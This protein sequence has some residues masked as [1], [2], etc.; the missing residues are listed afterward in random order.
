MGRMKVMKEKKEKKSEV[1]AHG[2]RTATRPAPRCEFF[3]K[4]SV[5]GANARDSGSY[6]QATSRAHLPPRGNR[7]AELRRLRD[8]QK[9]K[10]GHRNRM[11]QRCLMILMP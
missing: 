5:G 2:S 8:V 1:R 7:N 10:Q 3:A 9:G 11:K 6:L 4:F